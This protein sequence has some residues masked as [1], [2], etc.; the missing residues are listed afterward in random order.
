M[1]KLTIFNHDSVKTDNNGGVEKVP[2]IYDRML[3]TS[4]AVS[5]FQAEAKP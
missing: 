1:E 2:V 5:N 3:R 4:E